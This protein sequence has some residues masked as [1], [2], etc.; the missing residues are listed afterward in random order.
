M[1]DLLQR[2]HIVSEVRSELVSTHP[3]HDTKEDEVALSQ[4]CQLPSKACVIISAKCGQKSLFSNHL[5][6]CQCA[7]RIYSSSHIS[8]SRICSSLSIVRVKYGRKLPRDACA[9]NQTAPVTMALTFSGLEC[10]TMSSAR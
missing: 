7:H 5:R 6:K 10:C 4:S 2:R 1:D 3:G 9:A 8:V